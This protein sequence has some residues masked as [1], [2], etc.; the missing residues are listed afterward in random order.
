[1]GIVYLAF[2]EWFKRFG[3]PDTSSYTEV[4]P[5][6]REDMGPDTNSAV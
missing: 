1:M 5:F 6:A 3:P 4:H 2:D